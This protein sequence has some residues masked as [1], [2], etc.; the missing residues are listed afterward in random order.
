MHLRPS[1]PINRLTPPGFAWLR[2]KCVHGY[3]S[4]KP[5]D[6]PRIRADYGK[7]SQNSGAVHRLTPPGFA[8]T[9]AV[10]DRT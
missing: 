6:A 7:K 5:P 3:R 10:N 9:A 4:V 1:T 8:P 2:P